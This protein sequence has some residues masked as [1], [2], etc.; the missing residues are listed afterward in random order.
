MHLST[1]LFHI[2]QLDPAPRTD[3]GL[4]PLTKRSTSFLL[5]QTKPLVSLAFHLGFL[6]SCS[7]LCCLL[8][9]LTHPAVRR[10]SWRCSLCPCIPPWALRARCTHHSSYTEES[11]WSHCFRQ[12]LAWPTEL[13]HRYHTMGWRHSLLP[14]WITL[15][16]S[17]L[18]SQILLSIIMKGKKRL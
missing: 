6:Q 4:S 16:S 13:I 8:C 1:F 7:Q 11:D 5:H 14:H 18:V 2:L 9:P 10:Q 17:P 12:R 3:S 15:A